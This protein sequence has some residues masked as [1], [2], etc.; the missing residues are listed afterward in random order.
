MYELNKRAAEIAKEAAER[1]T[2]K[3][4]SKPRYVAGAVGPTNRTA[5]VASVD[6]PLAR[7]VSTCRATWLA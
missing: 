6:N 5:S 1:W 2:A 3:D 4:P 7:N